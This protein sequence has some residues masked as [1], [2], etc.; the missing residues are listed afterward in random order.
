VV[1][2][3][4]IAVPVGGTNTFTFAPLAFQDLSSDIIGQTANLTLTFRARTTEGEITPQV[5]SRQL[6]VEACDVP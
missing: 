1:G 5:V 4:S 3:G 2:L 6:F